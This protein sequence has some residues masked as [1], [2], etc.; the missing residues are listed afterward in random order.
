MP[1]ADDEPPHALP[2]GPLPGVVFGAAGWAEAVT[3]GAARD[4]EDARTPG[5]DMAV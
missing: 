1:S 4:R 2:E 3:P 5:G